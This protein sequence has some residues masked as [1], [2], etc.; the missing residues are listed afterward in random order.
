MTKKLTKADLEQIIKDLQ[1][2]AEQATETIQALQQ[3]LMITEGMVTRSDKELHTLA[4]DFLRF[5]VHL[6][7]GLKGA[8]ATYARYAEYVSS[9]SPTSTDH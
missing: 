9:I 2:E 1:Q 7:T 3:R 6:I 4:E 8:R 5:Q